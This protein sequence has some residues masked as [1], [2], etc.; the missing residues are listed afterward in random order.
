MFAAVVVGLTA[1]AAPADW[2]PI[3]TDLLARETTGFGGP[4]G[5][6]VDHTSGRLFVDLSD[7]GVF[8]S[9]DRGKTWGRVEAS[10]P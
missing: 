3:A 5:V 1:T 2:R 8:T 9:A 7:R 10:P 6:V 4:C